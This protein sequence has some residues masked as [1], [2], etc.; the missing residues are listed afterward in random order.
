M[1]SLGLP[2]FLLAGTPLSRIV[3]SSTM[4]SFIVVTSRL[5]SLAHWRGPREGTRSPGASARVSTSRLLSL[6]HRRGP[7]EDSNRPAQTER[8]RLND[9]AQRAQLRIVVM[10]SQKPDRPKHIVAAR[11]MWCTLGRSLGTELSERE[12]PMSTQHAPMGSYADDVLL[13]CF[14][15]RRR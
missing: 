10:L 15:F 3:G 2:M 8:R 1:P 5:L 6:A 7:R 4:D 13:A 14:L 9:M 12:E 11:A